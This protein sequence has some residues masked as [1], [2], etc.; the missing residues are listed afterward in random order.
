M[1]DERFKKIESKCR[2]NSIEEN[3]RIFKI[4]K[5]GNA[6]KEQETDKKEE[7][8]QNDKNKKE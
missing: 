7:K 5:D 8:K 3:L 6:V 1:R 2:N 4:M